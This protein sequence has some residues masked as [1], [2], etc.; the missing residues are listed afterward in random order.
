MSKHLLIFCHCDKGLWLLLS[1]I[2]IK[3]LKGGDAMGNNKQPTPPKPQPPRP[4]PAKP[5]DGW[6]RRSGQPDKIPAPPKPKN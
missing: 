6:E 1:N 5:S 3:E 4:Q 2:T